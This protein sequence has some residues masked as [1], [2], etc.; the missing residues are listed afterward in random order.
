M[1][2]PT[3]NDSAY[4]LNDDTKAS[5]QPN[6]PTQPIDKRVD[7]RTWVQGACNDVSN[8]MQAS[9]YGQQRQGHEPSRGVETARMQNPPHRWVQTPTMTTV[10]TQRMGRSTDDYD[11]RSSAEWWVIAQ[12]KNQPRRWVPT[13]T[14]AQKKGRKMREDRVQPTAGCG[15]RPRPHQ[16]SRGRKHQ[17]HKTEGIA[18]EGG[19]G[20]FIYYVNIYT[21]P[22]RD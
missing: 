5:K 8:D 19:W 21:Y 6:D 7:T 1:T 4:G 3:A 2:T 17:G 12:S 14:Q 20:G 9:G 10:R 11:H 18:R 16:P 13:T 22:R 15:R